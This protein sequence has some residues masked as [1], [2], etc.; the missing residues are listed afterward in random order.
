MCTGILRAVLT[1]RNCEVIHYKDTANLTS[2]RR[3]TQ[4]LKTLAANDV[5]LDDA[6]LI[7]LEVNCRTKHGTP[8]PSAQYIYPPPS[9]EFSDTVPALLD[10]QH[11]VEGFMLLYDPDLLVVT[12]GAYAAH[13]FGGSPVWLLL[14]APPS[15]AKTEVLGLLRDTPGNYA[16]SELTARTFASGLE[17]EGQD[18]S[19]LARLRNEVLV[20]KDFTTVLS[21]RYEER[22]AILAQL[23]EIFDGKY[24]KAWGT[25]K[26]LHWKGRLGFLAGV[27]PVIDSYYSAMAVLGE[28]FVM[29]RITQANRQQVAEKALANVETDIGTRRPVASGRP[30]F[31]DVADDPARRL[32]G[33]AQ[34]TGDH[35]HLRD[36]VSLWRRT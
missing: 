15:G 32:P 29:L 27:T 28:R 13:R 33:H 17:T 11:A 35:R 31:H 18:P 24:D 10:I 22:Q 4:I 9:P 25:G 21:M 1:V 20:L 12:L 7:G 16:L 26:E 23:R 30:F 5:L 8:P 2:M 36:A 3:R 14:V 34:T 6:V 19:L